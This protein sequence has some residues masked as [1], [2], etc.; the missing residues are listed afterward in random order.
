MQNIWSSGD[1]LHWI[2]HRWSLI[3]WSTHGVNRDSE[4]LYVADNSEML[5]VADNSEITE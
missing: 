1:R 4:M 3:I 5:Y 2:Q